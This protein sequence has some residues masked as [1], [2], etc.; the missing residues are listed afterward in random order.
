MLAPPLPSQIIPPDPA[1]P[2]GT[3][4]QQVDWITFSLQQMDKQLTALM[5]QQ[6]VRQ[7]LELNALT[8]VIAE[9][10]MLQRQEL[11][12][13]RDQINALKAKNG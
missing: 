4:D 1:A 6:F 3:L 12:R 10:G 11:M 9:Q 5:N 13:I 7:P 8:N 2:A